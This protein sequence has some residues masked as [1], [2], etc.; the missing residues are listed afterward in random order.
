MPQSPRSMPSTGRWGRACAVAA[1]LGLA[2]LAPAPSALADRI[3][4]DGS[5]AL[6]AAAEPPFRLAERI[7]DESGVLSGS[8]RTEVQTALTQLQDEDQIQLWVVFVDDFAGQTGTDWA[9]A[10]ADVSNLGANGVVLA[11]APGL[12]EYGF[13]VGPGSSLS[14]SAQQDIAVQDIEPQLSNE[15]WSGAAIAAADAL[16]SQIGGSTS[17][18]N[19]ALIAGGVVVVG[20]GGYLLYRR[21]RKKAGTAAADGT[22]PTTPVGEPEEPYQQLSDRSVSTLMATDDAVR[23]SEFELNAARDQFGVEATETFRVAFEQ[24]RA[25]LTAAFEIRQRIDDEVEES[26]AERRAMM[27]QILTRCEAA[28]AALDEQTER[29]EALRDLRSRLPQVLSELPAGIDAQR[30]RLPGAQSRIDSLA[31][32]YS[33]AALAAVFGNVPE[34]GHRLDFAAESLQ[35][36]TRA[37]AAGTAPSPAPTSPGATT[38]TAPEGIPLPGAPGGGPATAQPPVD[39]VLAARTAQEALQQAT[40][41]LDAIER[42][43]TELSAAVT[44]LAGYRSEV[45]QELTSVRGALAAAPAGPATADLSGRLDAV[46]TVIDLAGT[47][48]AAADP[49]TALHKLEEADQALDVILANATNA[50]QFQQ[51]SVAQLRQV[52]STAQ[53]EVATAQDYIGTRRGAVQSQARTRVAEAQRHLDQALALADTRTDVA[54]TEA[55]E[56]SR[57]A[58]EAISLAQSDRDQFGSSG[59]GGNLTGAI[60]GGLIG[61]MVSGGSRGRGYGGGGFGGG[62]F[63][64]GFGGGSRG[65][66]GGFGGGG[67]SRGVGGRF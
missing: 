10:T 31:Q 47:P 18:F 61:G 1:L 13:A 42:A 40:T 5:V 43:D 67:G 19:P 48:G 41:L 8:E 59:G 38:A 54:L 21:G 49:V 24:A 32:R 23:Q 16:R 15:D 44:R 39:Q 11:V 58:R 65:G 12:R 35:E 28:D 56:A 33:P 17:G 34:A 51:R 52:L 50:Q 7:T 46:A 29:F 53:S 3:S 64:G 66:G 37:S 20:G 57:L 63:G 14:L 26:E 22:D 25:E 27:A 60:L 2:G 62:G 55:N 30:S 6:H 36:A 4:G 9:E 45:A